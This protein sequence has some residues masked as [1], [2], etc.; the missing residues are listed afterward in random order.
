MTQMK[1]RIVFGSSAYNFIRGRDSGTTPTVKIRLR[2][3]NST[4]GTS[5]SVKPTPEW[6]G[7]PSFGGATRGNWTPWVTIP[8]T[9][10]TSSG[11]TFS[12]YNG[13]TGS[14]YAIWDRAEVQITRTVTQ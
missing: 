10:F 3:Q 12:F 6:S 13:T 4:H 11:Y 5:S 8:Y 14:S 7:A 9:L 2:R 1:G